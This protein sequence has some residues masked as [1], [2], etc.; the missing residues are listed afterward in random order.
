MDDVDDRAVRSLVSRRPSCAAP[1][2]GGALPVAP[3]VGGALLAAPTTVGAVL[4][5]PVDRRSTASFATKVD[6]GRHRIRP[7]ERAWSG[8][9][10]VALR[11]TGAA[12]SAPT[13]IGAASGAPTTGRSAASSAPMTDRRFRRRH[14]ETGARVLAPDTGRDAWILPRAVSGD[15]AL[16][17]GG[18]AA[19]RRVV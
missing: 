11:P 8:T 5:P 2:V 4:A 17:S 1:A 18:R 13:E 7:T 12:S 10:A 9:G 6:R 3:F 16:G 19:G 14:D 15:A